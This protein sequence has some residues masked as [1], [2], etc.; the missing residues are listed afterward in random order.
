[1]TTDSLCNPAH[2]VLASGVRSCALHCHQGVDT[3]TVD[4]RPSLLH[5]SGFSILGYRLV[6]A[7][8]ARAWRMDLITHVPRLES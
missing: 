2:S 8:T 1:M 4:Y 5:S 7:A 6:C 3:C